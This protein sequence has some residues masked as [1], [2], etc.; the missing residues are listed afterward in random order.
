MASQMLGLFHCL[1]ESLYSRQLAVTKPQL[2]FYLKTHTFSTFMNTE[3]FTHQL[4]LFFGAGGLN[5]NSV[6]RV[7]LVKAEERKLNKF[8]LNLTRK[9]ATHTQNYLWV[10]GWLI[11]NTDSQG[12][13]KLYTSRDI[14]LTLSIKY[15]TL[16]IISLW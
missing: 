7:Y 1:R 16:N 6:V 9:M 14:L 15:S 3:S 12:I 10:K 11:I 8:R 13:E 5:Q 2:C 4:R